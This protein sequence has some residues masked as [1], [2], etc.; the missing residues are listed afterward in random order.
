MACL[1]TFIGGEAYGAERTVA[2]PIFVPM[3]KNCCLPY[4]FLSPDWYFLIYLP[5]YIE[6]IHLT[7]MTYFHQTSR[8]LRPPP[9]VLPMDHTGGTASRSPFLPAQ[10]KWHSAAYVQSI[11]SLPVNYGAVIYKLVD[12]MSKD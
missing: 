12:K 8:Q 4:H 9:G 6:L 3:G 1:S 11:F 10:C 2:R 7:K 5:F